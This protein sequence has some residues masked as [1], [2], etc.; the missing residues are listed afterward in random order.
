V[1]TNVAGRL[2][3]RV[4]VGGKPVASGA[5]QLAAG[6]GTITF[7]FT[8]RARRALAKRRKAA[9]AIEATFAAK[10]AAPLPVTGT[11]TVRR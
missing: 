4:L 3:G 11:V 5:A 7:R 2:S 8:K 10:G 1:T 9:F 6:A